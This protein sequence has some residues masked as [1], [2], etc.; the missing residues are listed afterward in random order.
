MFDQ[1]A[2]RYDFLNHLLSAGRDVAWRRACCRALPVQPAGVLLDLCGGT[3]DFALTYARLVGTPR[4]ALV[5]DFSYNMLERALPKGGALLP[6]QLDALRLPLPDAC[7]DVALNGFGMRNL[8]DVR[9]GLVE[10]FRTLRPGGVFMTLEFFR[11]TNPFTRFFYGVLAPLSIP[12]V[13]F[14]FSKADAYDYLVRSIRKFLSVQEYAALAR[15]T[16]FVVKDI[17]AC[18]GGIA[19]RVL[20]EKSL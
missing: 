10:V 4:L 6:V 9:Q 5:G 12:L 14:I 15:Q 2:H 13:G 3:G 18:D 11:P 1:I 17:K 7:A 8:P 20:L 16:G 19:Y